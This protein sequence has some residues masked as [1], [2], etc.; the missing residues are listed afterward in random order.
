MLERFDG[1]VGRRRRITA[2]LGQKMVAGNK[3][4]AE[5]LA[6]R[7][8]LRAIE[9]G[10][11]LIEQGGSDNDV[12]FILAG[13][14]DIVVNGHKVARRLPNEH[15]GEMAAIEP[16]QRRSASVVAAEASVVAV[17]SET[18][19]S[20]FGRQ[21]PEIYLCL[22]RELARR[23]L[24]RNALVGTARENIRVFIISSVEALPVARLVQ[25]AFARD[26]FTTM[27][28]TDGVFKVSNYALESLEDEVD[29]SD[30]AIAIAHAD[31]ITEYR[32]SDW[33]SPRDNVI[34][35]LGLFMGR[36]GRH[37]AILM[38]PRG[39]GVKLPSDLAGI[40]TIP[41]RFEKGLDAAAIMGPACNMLREHILRLGPNN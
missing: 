7:L 19:L 10:G 5:K 36:L 20:D 22:A 11:R 3:D 41:Y 24:Q 33:P 21:Y 37:R 39:E 30:F 18:D 4:L 25:N 14:L 12:Y 32:G 28:W 15:V 16:T 29:K 9:A 27:I 23:L 13:A 38:E 2:L 26:P 40:T 35:E 6:D 34:F 31:D 1:D 17:L 8:P